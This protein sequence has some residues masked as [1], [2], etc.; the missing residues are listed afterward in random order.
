MQPGRG[1]F[2]EVATLKGTTTMDQITAGQALSLKDAELL[3]SAHRELLEAQMS[4]ETVLGST[5]GGQLVADAYQRVATFRVLLSLVHA[6]RDL[7]IPLFDPATLIVG[8]ARSGKCAGF[9]AAP[10]TT[11]NEVSA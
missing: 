9:V 4:G 3:A 7:V 8:E 2:C 6:G 11:R 1:L 10:A 5:D